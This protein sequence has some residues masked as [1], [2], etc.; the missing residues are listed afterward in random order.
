MTSAQVA[1]LASSSI[2]RPFSTS[3]VPITGLHGEDIDSVASAAQAWLAASWLAVLDRHAD[4]LSRLFSRHGVSAY[5]AYLRLMMRPL[6]TAMRA[7]C[8]AVYPGLPGSFGASRAWFD[9]ESR[10]WQRWCWSAV[11]HGPSERPLGTIVTVLH[12][13][14][15]VFRVPRAPE[16]FALRTV[17]LEAVERALGH[18]SAGFSAAESATSARR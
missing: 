1:A 15:Q 2:A 14:R 11:V 13:D 16:V 7:G 18:R 5:Q 9:A 3:R 12:H 6:E 8:L 17:G 10:S 4:R